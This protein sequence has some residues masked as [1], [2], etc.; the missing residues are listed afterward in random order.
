MKIRNRQVGGE[1]PCYVIA[2]IAQNHDGELA[3][4]KRL[5]DLAAEAGADAVKLQT[6]RGTD[7]CVPTQRS[8]D[9]PWPPAWKYQYWHQFLD[10]VMLPFRWY[11]E[12]VRYAHR[13]GLAFI[14][15]PCSP[16]RARFLARVG[17]DAIKI[18]SMDNDNLPLLRAV[19]RL[20]LPVILS[21]GMATLAEVEAGLRELGWPRRRDRA[22]LHCVSNYPA[23]PRTANLPWLATLAGAFEL[24]IGYSDHALENHAAVAAVALG[25]RLLEKHF[26][27]DRSRPGPDHFFAL[28]PDGLRDLVRGARSARAAATRRDYHRARPDDASAAR[29]K[30]S[31][32]TARDLPKGHR[33]R[34]ADLVVKRPRTGLAPRHLDELIGLRTVRAV[35]AHRPVTWALVKE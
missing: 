35:R 19:G 25:A 11:P 13:R 31:L 3:Q 16:E 10:R 5:I 17:A 4:A 6:F 32:H 15:T 24:P 1:Q 22:L 20:R 27:T 12:L 14:A 26:T 9:Y 21:T 29:M 18:A 30:R 2:E 33:L 28:E 23:D 7:I 8:R 34:A